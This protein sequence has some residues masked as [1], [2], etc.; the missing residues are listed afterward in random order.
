[1]LVAE[2]LWMS[3]EK[4]TPD[5]KVHRA[6]M[7]PI[8]G[9][10]DPGVP[11]V[12][13]MN[14]VIWDTTRYRPW[15]HHGM[16]TLSTLQIICEGNQLVTGGFS[17]KRAIN[18]VWCFLLLG[19]TSRCWTNSQVTSDMYWMFMWHHCNALFYLNLDS[20]HQIFSPPPPPHHCNVLFYLNLDSN[21]QISPPHFEVSV[22]NVVQDPSPNRCLRWTPCC[23]GVVLYAADCSETG[24]GLLGHFY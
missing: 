4:H 14:C 22:S 12:G 20:N 15:E 17:Y 9:Q 19:W 23:H 16:V 6:N 10:Q 11:H 1:M 7:G 13:P 24:K 21:H 5:S 2:F 8:W 3:L 18:A